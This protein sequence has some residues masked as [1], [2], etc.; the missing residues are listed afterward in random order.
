MTK[1]TR[2]PAASWGSDVT[3]APS[4]KT[5]NLVHTA[6][7]FAMW[8]EVARAIAGIIAR[9]TVRSQLAAER[10]V[11]PDS[12]EHFAGRTVRGPLTAY[13]E[14]NAIRR[15]TLKATGGRTYG[16]LAEDDPVAQMAMEASLLRSSLFTSVLAF[17]VAASEIALGALLALVGGVLSSIERRLQRRDE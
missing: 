2:H 6:A 10:I 15:I 8:I 17:G 14:A 5:Q 13:E 9:T 12:A 1:P 11:V 7:R 4:W 16:E 3:Q